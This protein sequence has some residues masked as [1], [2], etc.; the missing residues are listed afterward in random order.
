MT[1]LRSL[2]VVSGLVLI[3]GV[4]ACG[5]TSSTA[6]PDD[7]RTPEDGRILVA[8]ETMVNLE[9][10]YLREDEASGSR[11]VRTEVAPGTVADVSGGRGLLPAATHLELDLVLGPVDDGPTRVRRKVSVDVDGEVLVTIR[12]LD[13]KDL[14]SIEIEVTASPAA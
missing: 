6:P 5:G 8:N 2:L 4:A 14:F 1:G 3:C 11:L 9:V 13:P 10:A 7:D 12:L